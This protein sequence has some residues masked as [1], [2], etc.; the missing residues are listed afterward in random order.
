[1]GEIESNLTMDLLSEFDEDTLNDVQESDNNDE[2]NS[3]IDHEPDETNKLSTDPDPDGIFKKEDIKGGKEESVGAEDG[4]ISPGTQSKSGENTTSKTSEKN[5]SPTTPILASVAKACY[6]D[7]IFPDLT[8]DEINAIKDSESFAAAMRKQIDAG[9][10]EEQRKLKELLSNGVEPDEIQRYSSVINYLDTISDEM[11]SEES[12]T[13]ENL[14]K[15]IIYNDYLNRGFKPER[16]QREMERSINA[17]TDIED[18]KTCLEGCKEF[19]NENFNTLIEERRVETEKQK[20]Q[21]EK[22]IKEFKERVLNTEDPFDGLSLDKATRIA[23][24][25]NMTKPIYKDEQGN[26]LTAIQ[27]YAK[28]NS[29]NAQY[30][31]TLMYTLTNGFKDLNKLVNIKLQKEKKSALRQL[32]H[33][34]NNTRVAGDGSV[35]FSD[36]NDNESWEFDLDL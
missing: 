31:Y 26:A 20:K 28:D 24:F 2:F 6:E 27:K 22:T 15:K 1:M 8:E 36:N 19:Y 9:L 21:Q 17:G 32:E 3:G 18:A 10:E 23:I 25:N 29:L 5:T 12:P 35:D 33:T 13:G 16:A 14:R 4:T 11:L 34:L 7:G 30:Y